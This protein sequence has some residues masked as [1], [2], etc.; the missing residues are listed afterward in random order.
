MILTL[1]SYVGLA[2]YA[3]DCSNMNCGAVALTGETGGHFFICFLRRARAARHTLH[4][5]IFYG[6]GIIMVVLW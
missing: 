4:H 5:F 2:M 3:A 1:I 6:I